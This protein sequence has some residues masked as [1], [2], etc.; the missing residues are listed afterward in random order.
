MCATRAPFFP[1]SR[2]FALAIAVLLGATPLVASAVTWTRT[3]IRAAPGLFAVDV[4]ADENGVLHL[5]AW[6]PATSSLIYGRREGSSWSFEDI[7]FEPWVPHATSLALD[8]A[9]VPHVAWTHH[10]PLEPTHPW[11]LRH[12][13]RGGEGWLAETVDSLGTPVGRYPALA[14]RGGELAIGYQAGVRELRCARPGATG[15]QLTT[16]DDA[17]ADFHG[18]RLSAAIGLDGAVHLAYVGATPETTGLRHASD[19]GV[20]WTARFLTA[21]GS[22]QWASIAV[23]PENRPSIL[24]AGA[25]GPNLAVLHTVVG[26]GVPWTTVVDDSGHVGEGAVHRMDRWGN[27]HAAYLEASSTV[28]RYARRCGAEWRIERA[29]SLSGGPSGLALS[30]QGGAQIVHRTD[31]GELVLVSAAPLVAG[32]SHVVLSPAARGTHFT[33]YAV[34]VGGS[35]IP[36]AEVIVDFSG[37]PTVVLCRP[38]WGE[39]YDYAPGRYRVRAFADCF[40]LSELWI[41]GGGSSHTACAKVWVNG[42]AVSTLPVASPDLDGDRDVDNTDYGLFLGCYGGLSPRCDFDGDGT[43]SIA[44]LGIF[45]AVYASSCPTAVSA[46]ADVPRVWLGAAAPNPAAGPVTVRFSLA[47]RARVRLE[48]LDLLGR[49]VRVLV[50]DEWLRAG[51]HAWEWDGRSAA[52]RASAPGVYRVRLCAAGETRTGAL[53]RLR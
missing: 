8:G 49:R 38:G 22:G 11:A 21:D 27:P 18:Q 42:V 44:D 3:G 9:G 15:W 30:P 26:N 39:P 43:V 1:C 41:G 53:V 37:C 7:V 31:I 19:A 12:A 10:D 20:G 16:V 47:E 34:D 28:V 46:D 14:I 36:G 25:R 40:G 4:A 13:T 45:N 17:M 2:W 48:V 33:V 5:S 24:H 6:D 23:D 50:A 52:G 51:W 35:P 32:A 29:D